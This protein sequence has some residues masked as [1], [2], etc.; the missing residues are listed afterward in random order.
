MSI[1]NTMSPC[2]NMIST[3]NNMMS[4]N[5]NNNNKWRPTIMLKLQLF[6]HDENQQHDEH[7]QLTTT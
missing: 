6:E 2:N 3:N 4:F 1:N 5:N 7:L